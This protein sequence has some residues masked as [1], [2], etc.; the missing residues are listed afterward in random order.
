MTRGKD[1]KKR[2][3]LQLIILTGLSGA[4]KSEAIR[5]FEDAGFFC[6]DNLP[7]SLIYNLGSTFF[8]ETKNKKIAIVIDAR[9]SD[10]F[11][12]LFEGLM[13]LKKESIDYQVV[14]LE[15]SDD[16]LIKRFKETR[17]RHPLS[18]T[19]RILNAIEKERSRL[20]PL[21]DIADIIIDTSNITTRDLHEKLADTVLADRKG[22]KL[23]ISVVSFGYRYGV[24]TDADIVLDVRFI[25]NPYYL[26]D[27]KNL[28][29]R[30]A[31]IS[32]FVLEKPEA[33]KFL[34]LLTKMAR[35]LIPQYEK[36]GKSYL[37]IAIGCT[38]GKHRSVVIS[39]EIVKML[40]KMG[41][42]PTLL[43]RDLERNGAK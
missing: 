42:I 10:F 12:H 16:I 3:D 21:R 19:G 6:I 23:Q 24:P 9:G 27:L 4:G 13:S 1:L 36:E 15:A 41:Y 32:E 39:E 22:K 8:K 37:V 33:R 7:A 26:P 20:Q 43:H 40:E 17:R 28:D 18:H 29:G 31:R 2:E 5:Y 30:T 11:D 14:F 38:G 35:F 34:D 25:T